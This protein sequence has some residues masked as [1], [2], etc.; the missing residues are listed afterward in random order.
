MKIET[1]KKKN[2]TDTLIVPE[3]MTSILKSCLVDLKTPLP[4]P[5]ILLSVGFDYH[6]K[7]IPICT[8]GEFSCIV[9]PSKTKKSFLKSLLCSSFIG[10]KSNIFTPHIS[11]HRTDDMFI[12]DVDTEQGKYYAQRTFD[13]TIKIVGDEYSNYVPLYTRKLTPKQR[14]ELLEWIFTKS[15]YAGKISLCFIDGI[16]DLLDDAN[17][18]V[19]SNEIS[20]H[21]LRWTDEYKIHVCV[22]IHKAY[23]NDKATGHLGSA[24]TKKAETLIYID[25]ITDN[26]GV[27]TN[28]N[29]VRIRCGV[30]RGK[31][32]E[33]FFMSVNVE[34]LPYTHDADV[35]AHT[36]N[37]K[38]ESKNNKPKADLFNPDGSKANIS[39]SEVLD[40]VIKD[41]DVP[42]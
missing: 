2:D 38:K 15:P 18:L 8:E 1:V 22:I 29:T 40:P 11:G 9:A 5:K 4:P 42:F 41:D 10:G 12:I 35:N 24:V 33:E 19:M 14:V 16:A 13:R 20:G 32:F 39:K 34:G 6:N 31:M 7:P 23:G 36:Q 30:S 21:L 37:G 27:I 26:N 3:D 25:P 28:F 17:N